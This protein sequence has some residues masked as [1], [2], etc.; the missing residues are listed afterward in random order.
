MFA[1]IPFSLLIAGII[2]SLILILVIYIWLKT[3]RSSAR[4]IDK[5]LRPYIKDELKNFII[6]DGVGGLLEIEHLVSMEQGLLLIETYPIS[7]YLF[8]AENI[9]QWTQLIEGRSFKFDNP[10]RH[11]RT[12]YQALKALVPKTP[13]FCRVIFSADSHFPKG[14]PQEVSILS[15]LAED[16]QEVFN[17][18]LVPD[19]TKD[20]WDKVVR[21]SRKKGQGLELYGDENGA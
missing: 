11:M 4:Q 20:A 15:S 6:P 2:G 18:P 8:G 7:G 21:T 1:E 5:M 3:P 19:K 14:K 10:L 17:S 12:S 13:I 9:D 16:M